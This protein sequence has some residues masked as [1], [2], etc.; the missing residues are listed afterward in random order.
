MKRKIIIILLVL[1]AFILQSTVFQTISVGG[2]VPNILLIITSCFGFM[3]GK[4]EGLFVGFFS[5]LLIDIFYGGGFLG[6]YAM[7]YMFMGYF[8]GSFHH[9]FYPE[10][11]KLP[12]LFIASSDFVYCIVSYVALFLLRGRLNVFGY[13]SQIIIPEVVYTVLVTLILYR[14]ILFI[15][16]SLEDDEKKN[17]AK[18]V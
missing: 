15:N 3:R 16:K 7:I 2:V 9:V 18:F 5:G 6:V 8:N 14:P 4:K 10:D 12:I 17:E 1:I 13:L 11:I